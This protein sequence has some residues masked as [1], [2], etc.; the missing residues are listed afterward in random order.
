MIVLRL[1][2]LAEFCQIYCRQ[3]G[4]STSDLAKEISLF[5]QITGGGG[6]PKKNE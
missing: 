3:R 1:V 4:N 5:R 6:Q 2:L